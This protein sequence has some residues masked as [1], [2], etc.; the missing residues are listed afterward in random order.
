MRARIFVLV[1]LSF[2][3]TITWGKLRKIHFTGKEKTELIS[4]RETK[5]CFVSLVMIN[6]TI[7]LV[8]QKK[9]PRKQLAVVRDALASYVAEDLGIAQHIAIV[10]CNQIFPGKMKAD[11]PATIHTL[12]PGQTVREQKESKYN[13]LRLRQFWAGAEQFIDKGLTRAII[14]YMTWHK[15][16]PIIVALDLLIANSD[17][18]CG[19]LCYDPITDT[20]FAI[21]MDDTFNK[22]LCALACEKFNHMLENDGVIFTSSEIAA[23]IA[24]K[25]TLQ[26]LVKRHNPHILIK[27]LRSFARKAGFYKGSKS[28]TTRIENKLMHYENMIVEGYASARKLI[29]LLEKIIVRKSR[30]LANLGTENNEFA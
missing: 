23:L 22:D 1:I 11:W 30:K 18:H 21:D 28:Y 2:S 7:Y 6:G 20:F 13:A 29:L 16:L 14:T 5:N 27:K 4:T 3:T 17:R 19:N 12:A 15:Q 8:K 10:P 9:D 26:L 25:E 24:M